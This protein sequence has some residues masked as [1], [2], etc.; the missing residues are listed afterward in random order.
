L[1]FPNPIRRILNR[2]EKRTLLEQ[3][4]KQERGKY[5]VASQKKIKKARF[6]H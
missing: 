4:D 6:G 1:F 2:E 5:R 3:N